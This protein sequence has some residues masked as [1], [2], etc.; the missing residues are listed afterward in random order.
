MYLHEPPTQI[1]LKQD[2][3]EGKYVSVILTNIWTC[4]KIKLH[5]SHATS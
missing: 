4:I 1:T 2:C 5:G 3:I